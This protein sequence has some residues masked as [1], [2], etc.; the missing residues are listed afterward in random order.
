MYLSGTSFNRCDM[1]PFV[2]ELFLTLNQQRYDKCRYD[3]S[4]DIYMCNQ[5]VYSIEYV[6]AK[7]FKTRSELFKR[8]ASLEPDTRKHILLPTKSHYTPIDRHRGIV[9][10]EFVRCEMD[11][12]DFSTQY[13]GR[14]QDAF[15]DHAFDID[16]FVLTLSMTLKRLHEVNIY[17]ADIKPENILIKG[18]LNMFT[19]VEYA[20]LDPPTMTDRQ[21]AD[22]LYR[23]LSRISKRRWIR[24]LKY[25]PSSEYPLT[26]SM[27][28]R[29]D[30]FALARC[31]SMLMLSI[32]HKKQYRL[33]S[34]C[35]DSTLHDERAM[36]RAR[37]P[38][39]MAIPY[40][41]NCADCIIEY[42]TR[43]NTV[44][45]DNMIDTA[46]QQIRERRTHSI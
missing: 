21:Y 11:M 43:A 24:T 38:D 45:L 20:F 29:N 17:L 3:Y 23:D 14:A 8:I 28:I 44:F 36:I 7:H 18:G 4:K 41:A 10:Q 31:I 39:V 22:S 16:R 30:V 9:F 40:I 5:L 6:T 27:F 26:K 35:E 25:L 15:R 32:C 2:Q 33:F 46:H 42:S 1:P 37:D 13:R 34:G 19:D 12:H